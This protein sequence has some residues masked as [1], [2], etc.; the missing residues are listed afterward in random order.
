MLE[1]QEQLRALQGQQEA[2]M[3]MQRSAEHALAVIEDT[4]ETHTHTLM[5]VFTLNAD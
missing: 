5:H 2:L 1:Q 3:A 4:G